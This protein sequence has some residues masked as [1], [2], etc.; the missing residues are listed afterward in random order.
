MLGLRYSHSTTVVLRASRKTARSRIAPRKAP[1]QA[2]AAA[3]VRALLEASARILERDGVAG[4]N[5]NAVAARAGTSI[6]SL[7]QYFPG[8]DALLAALV[9]EDAL[10][11]AEAFGIV[12][13]E[14]AALPFVDGAAAL[15]DLALDHQLERPRLA[16][17]LDLEE[18]RLPPQPAVTD[19]L[20]RIV[21]ALVR[22]LAAH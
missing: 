10:A 12:A 6:G 18:R 9:R 17:I 19:A 20:G 5:T 16:R 2:R 1:V 8:K 14:A 21:A 3:T 22:F 4:F 11:F 13:A 7:Y 15:V